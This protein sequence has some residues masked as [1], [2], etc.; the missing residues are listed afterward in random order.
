M[1]SEPQQTRT[2]LLSCYPFSRVMCL[3]IQAS[4]PP[5]VYLLT[6]QWWF[7]Q[8]HGGSRSQP[9]K[10]PAFCGEASPLVAKPVR[11]FVAL[12]PHPERTPRV[13]L[14]STLASFLFATYLQ[15]APLNLLPQLSLHRSCNFDSP[16]AFQPEMRSSDLASQQLAQRGKKRPAP[17]DRLEH[18]ETPHT[19]RSAPSC[20]GASSS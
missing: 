2:A 17:G 13:G 12:G 20:P 10:H 8:I 1:R 16:V 4:P 11:P 19:F 14:F 7:L 15:V 5:L 9:W 3:R 6:R 18:T